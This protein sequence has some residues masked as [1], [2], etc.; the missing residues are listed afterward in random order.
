MPTLL[1]AKALAHE[2]GHH[3]VNTKGYI[4]TPDEKYPDYKKH[5][6]YEEEM[7]NR[8]AFDVLSSMKKKLQYKFGTLLM[9][10]FADFYY[11]VAATKWQEKKYKVAADYWYKSFLLNSERQETVEWLWHSRKK[12]KEK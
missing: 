12:I 8:Y 4:F 3:L 1:I 9:N 6:D 7:A 5:P 2:V 11:G 10:Y